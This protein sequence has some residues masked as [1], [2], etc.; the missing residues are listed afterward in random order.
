MQVQIAPEALEFRRPFTH[1]VRQ[2]IV[3]TNSGASPLLA[4]KIKTTAPKQYCVRPNAGT[5]PAGATREIEVLLQAMKE[6]PAPDF[7]CKDKFLV[8]TTQVPPEIAE[9]TD[10]DE[11]T[12]ALA[13]LWTRV[14]DAKKN[15]DE[16]VVLEKKLRCAFLPAASSTTA[17]NDVNSLPPAIPVPPSATVPVTVSSRVG[18]SQTP[19]AAANDTDRELRDAKDAI[20]RL[21]LACEGYK[22]EIERLN[23]LRQRRA[24]E[25]AKIGA[26]GV[27]G[28][29]LAQ[30][31]ANKGLPLPLAL[32]LALIAFILGV[33]LF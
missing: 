29:Q 9:I 11:Q 18:P 6:D 32:V 22:A 15:G 16:S 27:S 20:K 2:S 30:I 7:R 21:T 25:D 28:A 13:S 14:E 1:V 10:A 33:V 3:L 31:Q 26:A 17:A 12:A 23:V 4:F 24:A 19:A 8:Q 5:I